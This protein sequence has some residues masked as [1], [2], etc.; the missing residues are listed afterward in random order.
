MARKGKLTPDRFGWNMPVDSPLFSKLPHYFINAEILQITYET[1]EEAVLDLLPEGVEVATPATAVLTVF[2]FPFGTLG[3]YN[4]AAL[5]LACVWQGEQKFYTAYNLVDN[6]A[7]MGAGREIWGVPKKQA[8]IDI[9]KEFDLVMGTVERP[10]GNRLFTVLV[11]PEA[12]ADI[13]RFTGTSRLCLRV[14]PNVEEGRGPAVAELVDRNG[15]RTTPKE[16]WTGRGSLTFN[17]PS[18]I[19]PW[20]KLGVKRILSAT[21]GTYDYILG[22]GKVLR[23]YTDRGEAERQEEWSQGR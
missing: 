8:H 6:D 9:G 21:Y 12:P 22:Y 3:S 2:R 10:K 14:I 1:D 4:E 15:H 23:T 17:V 16:V 5:D 11:R 7:G 19:D 13:S 20:Y 18:E